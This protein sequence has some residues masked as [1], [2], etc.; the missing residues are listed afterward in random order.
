MDESIDQAVTDEPGELVLR[1][2]V[3]R[4]DDHEIGKLVLDIG[5]EPG[6]RLMQ[7]MHI[8]HQDAH[9]AG[10]QEIADFV[11]GH[12]VPEPAGGADPLSKRLQE[13]LVGGQYDELDD[14]AREA[15]PKC[16]QGTTLIL[17]R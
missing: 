3:A 4:H 6:S 5:N 11:R 15:G 8:E 2:P 13:G 12:D 14:L 9:A 1:V 10:H 7:R 16:G 17:G